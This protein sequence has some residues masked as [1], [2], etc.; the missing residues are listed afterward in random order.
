MAEFKPFVC[1][2]GFVVAAIFTGVDS[3]VD[4][5]PVISFLSYPTITKIMEE[6]I[7]I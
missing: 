7:D 2:Y 4:A 6:N 1:Y 5:H 3:V